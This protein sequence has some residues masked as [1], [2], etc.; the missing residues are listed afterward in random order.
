MPKSSLPRGT[1]LSSNDVD[2]VVNIIRA[3]T[4]GRQV[5]AAEATPDVD[6]I[7]VVVVVV[8]VV[9]LVVDDID[10]AAAAAAAW[11]SGKK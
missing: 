8:V 6:D 3:V 2:G 9:V 11:N 4:R 7:V 5:S 1:A 10:A